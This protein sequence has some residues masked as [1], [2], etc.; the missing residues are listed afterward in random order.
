[1]RQ[2]N[3][4]LSDFSLDRA[5]FTPHPS[6]VIGLRMLL[7]TAGAN[8]VPASEHQRILRQQVTTQAVQ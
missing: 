2:G 7:E 6:L 3:L 4:H 5:R 8:V 1:M